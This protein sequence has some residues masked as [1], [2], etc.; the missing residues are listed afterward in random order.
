MSEKFEILKNEPF[1]DFRGGLTRTF[2]A[3]WFSKDICPIQTS[4]S[5]TGQKGTLRGFHYETSLKKEWKCIS[6]LK[7][8]VYF[9]LIDLRPESDTYKVTHEA[10]IVGGQC[11]S[12]FVPAGYANAF[13]SL[14][15]DVWVSYAMGCRYEES[16]YAVLNWRDPLVRDIEWPDRPLLISDRD[17]G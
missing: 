17:R 5:F 12:Y 14:S 8:D 4:V 10:R 3:K 6:F 1:R 13:L 16:E 2:D 9:A 11:V 15:D 7:G